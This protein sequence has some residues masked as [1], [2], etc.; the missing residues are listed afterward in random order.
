MK[1]PFQFT[2]RSFAACITH[3]TIV[4]YRRN[5]GSPELTPKFVEYLVILCF[6]RQYSK[7]RYCC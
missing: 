2:E 1:G 4:S 5:Q 7:I 6:E 3:N